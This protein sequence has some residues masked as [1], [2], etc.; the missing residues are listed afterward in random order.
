M[1]KIKELDFVTRLKIA[2]SMKYGRVKINSICKEYGISRTAA[3]NIGLLFDQ[4][5]EPSL[6]DSSMTRSSQ[7]SKIEQS[8]QEMIIT[9]VLN[10]THLTTN[11]IR[12]LIQAERKQIDSGPIQRF[13]TQV[14]LAN[15]ELREQ[16]LEELREISD[17]KSILGIQKFAYDKFGMLDGRD[18]SKESYNADEQHY[19]LFDITLNPRIEASKTAVLYLF[20]NLRSLRLEIMVNDSKF[21]SPEKGE[22]LGKFGRCYSSNNPALFSELVLWY[23]SLR[24]STDQVT[25]V[26]IDRGSNHFHFHFQNKSFVELY[27]EQRLVLGEAT[28]F[29]YRKIDFKVN[30]LP[31]LLE[32]IMNSREYNSHRGNHDQI[33]LDYSINRIQQ[34]VSDHNAAMIKRVQPHNCSEYPEDKQG[35][36]LRKKPVVKYSE[37]MD[38]WLARNENHAKRLQETPKPTIAELM[39]DWVERDNN[40]H[41]P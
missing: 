27:G 7:P 16:Y 33:A 11:E 5:G 32:R 22:L 3:T 25:N 29:R 39:K 21:V 12:S 4:Y 34:F 38:C 23:E 31:K 8:L 35:T 17:A 20:L 30:F 6:R 14:G 19:L 13:L 18:M 26:Y 28:K 37:L 1:K 24:A 40:K 36:Q 2:K 41:T 10:H 15:E 9:I